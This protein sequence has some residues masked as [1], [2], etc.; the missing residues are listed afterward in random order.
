[1]S[2]YSEKKERK[3]KEALAAKQAKPDAAKAAKYD[4]PDEA[5]CERLGL[6]KTLDR[7]TPL[8]TRPLRNIL[9]MAKNTLKKGNGL[10][11]ELVVNGML[12]ANIASDVEAAF[13]TVVRAVD[14]L[15]EHAIKQ[16]EAR[17]PHTRL[18]HEMFREVKARV[19]AVRDGGKAVAE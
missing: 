16:E 6:S 10:A 9:K 19:A 3:L 15:A 12:P 2:K 18:N 11:K 13:L 7:A 5:T 4:R 8:R 17:N 14:E 1:M